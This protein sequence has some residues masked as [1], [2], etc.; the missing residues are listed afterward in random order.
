MEDEVVKDRHHRHVHSQA[1]NVVSVKRPYGQLERVVDLSVF[2]V[3]GAVSRHL[4]ELGCNALFGVGQ[5]SVPPLGV[6]RTGAS[7][8][9]PPRLVPYGSDE[10]ACPVRARGRLCDCGFSYVVAG[11]LEHVA[12]GGVN[13]VAIRIPRIVAA[14]KT[15][16][17]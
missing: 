7:G 9:P 15:A 14:V 2:H 4:W 16:D 8:N 1:V 10:V 12:L 6:G 11:K 3:H 17:C 13:L 5:V